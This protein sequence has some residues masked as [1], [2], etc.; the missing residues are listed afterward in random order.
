M[1]YIRGQVRV[2][3]WVSRI[4]RFLGRVSQ[5]SRTTV[6]QAI[7]KPRPQGLLLSAI[8]IRGVY[9]TESNKTPERSVYSMST[10]PI[11]SD[12]FIL[13]RV[14]DQAIIAGIRRRW[15]DQAIIGA[16]RRWAQVRPK[17][18]EV[19]RGVSSTEGK[20][21][22]NEERVNLSRSRKSE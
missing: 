2:P 6:A 3:R 16:L 22:W 21:N 10:E 5:A 1:G 15:S 19:S 17:A 9:K 4:L 8:I 13:A 14:N 20:T 11:L 12:Q 18:R 7:Q